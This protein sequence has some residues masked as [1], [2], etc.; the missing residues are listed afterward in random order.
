MPVALSHETC[1]KFLAIDRDGSMEPQQIIGGWNRPSTIGT[2][3]TCIRPGLPWIRVCGPAHRCPGQSRA[4][5]ELELMAGILRG[6]FHEGV[7]GLTRSPPQRALN[8]AKKP[9]IAGLLTLSLAVRGRI[10]TA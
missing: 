3:S 9:A 8:R 4:S 1:E 10:L 6:L 5:G 7:A 2:L